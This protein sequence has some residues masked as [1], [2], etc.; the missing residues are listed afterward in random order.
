MDA[1]MP[2]PSGFSCVVRRKRWCASMK[3]AKRSSM[4]PGYRLQLLLLALQALG[5]EVLQLGHHIGQHG[6]LDGVGQEGALEAHDD[7]LLDLVQGEAQLLVEDEVLV[8]D[9][10]LRHEAVVR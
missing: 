7:E 3:E 8:A 6:A 9:R 2:S 4:A 10:G 5:L 1:P